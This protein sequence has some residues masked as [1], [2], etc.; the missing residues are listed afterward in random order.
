MSLFFRNLHLLINT[1][2]KVV[3]ANLT[4]TL[5]IQSN[6]YHFMT[7]HTLPIL[8]HFFL[9]H[10]PWH[11]PLTSQTLATHVSLFDVPPILLQGI[12]H[13]CHIG[14]FL[15]I[16][17]TIYFGHSYLTSKLSSDTVRHQPNFSHTCRSPPLV[18][19]GVWCKRHSFRHTFFQAELLSQQKAPFCLCQKLPFEA[20]T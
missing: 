19:R 4:M 13:E 1:S 11:S 2:A 17:Q 7:F 16:S 6:I 5:I 14:L 12:S 8:G 10:L 9:A 18:L 3:D 20:L 15:D